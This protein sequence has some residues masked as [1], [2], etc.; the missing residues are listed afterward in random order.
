ME[1]WILQSVLKARK[2][3]DTIPDDKLYHGHYKA[4]AEMLY[5]RGLECLQAVE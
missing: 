5:K 4:L 1:I 2:A 3:I